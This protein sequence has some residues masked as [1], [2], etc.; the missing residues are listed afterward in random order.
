ML[1]ISTEGHEGASEYNSDGFEELV[2][3]ERLEFSCEDSENE[4]LRT[5]LR[6]IRVGF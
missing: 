3:E 5:P 2:L 1:K 4:A 6:T